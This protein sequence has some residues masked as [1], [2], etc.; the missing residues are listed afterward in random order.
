MIEKKYDLL[1]KK[2][3][4]LEREG[5]KKEYV[6]QRVE[7]KEERI[8]HDY[9]ILDNISSGIIA[10]NLEGKVTIFNKRA[11]QIIRAKADEFIGKEL[12]F[13]PSALADLLLETLKTGKTYHRE[14]VRILPQNILVGVSTSQFYNSRSEVIGAAMVF[15]DLLKI[16]EAQQ[17]IEQKSEDGFWTR[18]SHCLAHEIKNPLVSIST[19]TQLL[20]GY[21]ND[22]QFRENFLGTVSNDIRRL[23]NFV[24][25]LITIA[26]PLELNLQIQD[27]EKVI[28]EAL[29]SLRGTNY[30]QTIFIDWQRSNLPYINLD[31]DKLKE[32]LKNILINAMEAM[33]EGGALTISGHSVREGFV[34]LRFQDRGEGIASEN[35]SQVFLPFFTTKYG[36]SG[37]GL[38]LAKKI[39]EA[40]RGSIEVK[41][42][43]G[44][45]STF[46]VTLP[47]NTQEQDRE[48]ESKMGDRFDISSLSP[49]DMRKEKLTNDEKKNPDC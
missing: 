29:N 40:H 47:I 49:R 37:L 1:T 3:V 36:H 48:T 42:A 22:L 34:E 8:T 15:A 31:F 9:Q 6:A 17:S 41:S 30:P 4:P 18:F 33:P 46:S 23:N 27:I 32:A 45:G 5:A 10:V 44:A 26:S 24:E 12:A 35:L 14:E 7:S 19:Y 25:K 43:V 11:E 13:I 21:Y 16:K 38:T 28:N 2:W 39:I 20:P